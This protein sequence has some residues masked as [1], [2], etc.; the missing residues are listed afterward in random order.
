MKIEKNTI[1]YTSER[2]H[3]NFFYPSQYKLIIKEDYNADLM[4]WISGGTKVAIRIPKGI[5]MP[6][7]LVEN[8]T[9]NLSPPTT[10]TYTIVW[11]EKCLLN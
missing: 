3:K 6:L 8:I 1:C 4:P 2:G 10:N 5:L 7:D 9:A 11:I